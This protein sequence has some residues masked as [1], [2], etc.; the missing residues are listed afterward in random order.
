MT[1][2]PDEG[3]WDFERAQLAQLDMGL[4]MTPAERLRWLD[5]HFDEAKRL[6]GI[7]RPTKSPQ[8]TRR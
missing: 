2:I 7:A 4:R 5:E 1:A 8:S 6:Q 3:P